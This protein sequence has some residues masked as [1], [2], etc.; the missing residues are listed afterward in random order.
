MNLSR[1]HPLLLDWAGRYSHLRE[2]T[3]ADIITATAA[4]PASRCRQTLTALRSLFGHARKTGT[5]F[6]DPTR[7]APRPLNLLHPLQPADIS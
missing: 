4:L 6:A 2:F 5:I 1:V 3:A 7:D